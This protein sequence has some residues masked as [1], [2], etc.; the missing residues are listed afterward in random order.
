MIPNDITLVVV[1]EIV[2]ML[3]KNDGFM[4]RCDSA[5]SLYCTDDDVLL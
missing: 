3:L 5:T 1:T 2:D 4:V